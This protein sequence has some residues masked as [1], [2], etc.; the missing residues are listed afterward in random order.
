MES[1]RGFSQAHPSNEVSPHFTIKPLHSVASPFFP[2]KNSKPPP[3]DTQYF[4]RSW[5]ASSHIIFLLQTKS[6]FWSPI[7]PH[8]GTPLKGT[9][10]FNRPWCLSFNEIKALTDLFIKNFLFQWSPCFFIIKLPNKN[11]PKKA[12]TISTALHPPSIPW[13]K[14]RTHMPSC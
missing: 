6:T 12:H 7:S 13:N 11:P 2:S 1:F 8:T 4:N 14:S 5:Q 9:C 3:K 10:S